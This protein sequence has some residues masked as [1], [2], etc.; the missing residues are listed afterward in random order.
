M[1]LDDVGTK[2][3]VPPVPPTWVMES[4]PNDYQY[5]YAFAEDGVPTG[6]QFVQT[7]KILAELGYTDPGAGGLVRNFR[8]PGSINLKRG[9]FAAR[10]VEFHPDRQFSY[11]ALCDGFGIAPASPDDARA[12]WSPIAALPDDGTDD[13]WAWLL[14]QGLV[15]SRPNAEGWAAVVC[16]NA[17]QHTDGNPEGRY[18]PANR[19]FCCLH[20][21]CVGLDSRTFL[22]LGGRAGGPKT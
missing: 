1:M 19:A 22:D 12:S 15:A 3:K 17:A 6:A 7:V 21:H 13:V 9:G 11:L 14:A 4:S 16:P 5:G 20:G 2:S 18:S 10:L 8:L